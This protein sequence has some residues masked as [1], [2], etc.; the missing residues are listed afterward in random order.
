VLGRVLPG[1]T[2]A[3]LVACS[4]ASHPPAM[5]KTMEP[6]SDQQACTTLMNRMGVHDA[7]PRAKL[8]DTWSCDITTDDDKS[9]PEWWV[10][11]LRSFR[12]CDGIC[13]NLRGWFAV[14]RVTGEVREWDVGEFTIGGPVG[15]P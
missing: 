9:H 8:K 7:V 13:S 14:N 2:L 15:P 12:Q 10:I 1:I 6:L 4:K 5:V 11:G 3:S